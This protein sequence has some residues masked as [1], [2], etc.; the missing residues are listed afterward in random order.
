LSLSDY[1]AHIVNKAQLLLD[2][3]P[4]NPAYLAR[5]WKFESIPL[6]R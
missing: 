1:D 6:Q 2:A 4:R 5:N 3:K